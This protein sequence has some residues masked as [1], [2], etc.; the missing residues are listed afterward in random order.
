MKEEEQKAILSQIETRIRGR[1]QIVKTAAAKVDAQQKIRPDGVGVVY[2]GG[3]GLIRF[4]AAI[5]AKPRAEGIR[6]QIEKVEKVVTSKNML[7]LRQI[8]IHTSYVL[9]GVSAGGCGRGEIIVFAAIGRQRKEL[10][11]K[12]CRRVN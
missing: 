3:V 10:K 9:I 4:R 8:L 7:R 12:Q 5:L 2:D 6:G 11:F 1:T